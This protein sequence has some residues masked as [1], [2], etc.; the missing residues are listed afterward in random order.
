VPL[1][2]DPEPFSYRPLPP[3]THTYEMVDGVVRVWQDG[4]ARWAALRPRGLLCCW[5][6]ACPA[7]RAQR[8]QQPAQ[9]P[10]LFDTTPPRPQH[11]HTHTHTHTRV[12]TPTC[13]PCGGSS[14]GEPDLFPLPGT[15]ADFF[16]D[17][18]RV[19]R[20]ASLGPVK[21]FCHHR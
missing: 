10:N 18:H 5:L 20:Y 4:E 21:S 13:T 1:E 11:T 3:S 19:L 14:C 2:I 17:M 8:A 7:L 15:A 12:R 16:T 6:R 9:Q